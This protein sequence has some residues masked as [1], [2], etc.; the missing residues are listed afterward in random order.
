MFYLGPS[1]HIPRISVHIV[2]SRA[3]RWLAQG[4][5]A[6]VSGQRTASAW[7]RAWRPTSFTRET[8]GSA[9]RCRRLG[10]KGSRAAVL[11]RRIVLATVGTFVAQTRVPPLLGRRILAAHMQGTTDGRGKARQLW[12][13][14]LAFAERKII[15]RVYGFVRH[16]WRHFRWCWKEGQLNLLH[17]RLSQKPRAH[18]SYG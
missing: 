4:T 17:A 14:L 13:L 16:K 3:S 5:I 11:L 2:R 10:T 15:A 7:L 1:I 6:I 8:K 9:V 12:A 18:I